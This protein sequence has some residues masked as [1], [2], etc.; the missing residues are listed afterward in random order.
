VGAAY[1]TWVVIEKNQYSINENPPDYTA[2][3]RAVRSFCEKCGSSLTYSHPNRPD[4]LDVTAGT[5]NHPDKLSPDW[6]IWGKRKVEWV[7]LHDEL[8][9]YE[10]YQE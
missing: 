1:V 5:L 10:K 9:F 2:T 3:N 4:H 6:H 7:K 8:P